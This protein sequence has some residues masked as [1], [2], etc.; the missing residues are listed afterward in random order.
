MQTQILSSQV[1]DIFLLNPSCQYGEKP[2]SEIFCSCALQA[3]TRLFWSAMFIYSVQRNKWK[4]PLLQRSQLL[5]RIF[6][7]CLLS[8][9]RC[10]WWCSN[11]QRDTDYAP[12]FFFQQVLL[13]KHPSLTWEKE[14]P[15]EP[16]SNFTFQSVALLLFKKEEELRYCWHRQL[17]SRFSNSEGLAVEPKMWAIFGKVTE[18]WCYDE[19]LRAHLSN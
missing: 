1:R 13:Q 11:T 2:A 18:P 6:Q 5:P 10:W 4:E 15:F 17:L 9:V 14:K 12:Q 3:S 8:L 16:F 19:Y 7:I